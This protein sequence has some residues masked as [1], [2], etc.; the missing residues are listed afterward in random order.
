MPGSLLVAPA[1][2]VGKTETVPSHE[3]YVL[4]R[5]DHCRTNKWLYHRAGVARA[6]EHGTAGQGT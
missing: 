4:V 6:M 1:T 2:A 3:A 5:R